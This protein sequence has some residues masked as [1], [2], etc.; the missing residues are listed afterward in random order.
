MSQRTSTLTTIVGLGCL[1]L[2][3]I[4]CAAVATGL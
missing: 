3:L 1:L 2:A 4:I